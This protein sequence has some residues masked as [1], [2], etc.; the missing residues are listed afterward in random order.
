MQ[1]ILFLTI[2]FIQQT[3]AKTTPEACR[4]TRF[5]TQPITCIDSK[6]FNSYSQVQSNLNQFPSEL[7]EFSFI[8][9]N[10]QKLKKLRAAEL[11]KYKH[12]YRHL[13]FDYNENPVL[14]KKHQG[15]FEEIYSDFKILLETT[16]ELHIT[17][18][19]INI[20]SRQ[21]I[22]HIAFDLE[23]KKKELEKVKL[24]IFLK[25]RILAGNNIEKIMR[26][27]IEK[28]TTPS[29]ETFKSSFISDSSTYLVK[30][31]ETL[32]MYD[33]YLSRLDQN[34]KSNK[35]SVNQ[36]KF[37]DE[38]LDQNPQILEDIFASGVGEKSFSDPLFNKVSCQYYDKFQS[39]LQRQKTKDLIIDTSLVIGPFLLMGAGPIARGLS[40]TKLLK[41]GTPLASPYNQALAKSASFALNGSIIAYDISSLK[42]KDLE[43]EKK[44]TNLSL[45]S[46]EGAV[47]EINKCKEELSDMILLT[48]VG[49]GSV[50]MVKVSQHIS[51]VLKRMILDSHK[52]KKGEGFFEGMMKDLGGGKNQYI[53]EEIKIIRS[54]LRENLTRFDTLS[55]KLDSKKSAVQSYLK[56]N[57]SPVKIADFQTIPSKNLNLY[58][59]KVG[60]D[61]IELMYIPGSDIPHMHKS[62]NR[63]GHVALRIG[64]KVYHQTGGSGFKIESL[65]DFINKTKKNYKVYGQVLESSPK[66]RAIME[67]YFQVMH[68]KQLP[69]SFLQNN[70]SQSVCRAFDLAQIKK[71]NSAESLD[72][73][74]TVAKIK[75]S[76]RVVMKTVYNEDKDVGHN[77]MKL[78][79]ASNRSLFYG[80]PLATGGAAAYESLQ[81]VDLLI[82]F[83]EESKNAP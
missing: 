62:V 35:A 42:N 82:N 27:A 32:D 46:S 28:D 52:A 6:A 36:K 66:E 26:E 51:P 22:A 41:F 57:E 12:L 39:Y 40:L 16:R 37:I 48:S 78:L 73:I 19:K 68:E 55:D 2:L 17:Q 54:K 65:D 75:R 34:L 10:I 64:D 80:L 24:A 13:A 43:C 83:M 47:L 7:T 61:S 15:Q 67:E 20:L 81:M 25:N 76:D 3:I 72:P 14:L 30:Q 49:L 69:Y 4:D 77:Q 21:K 53:K 29:K 9:Q 11:D 79:T 33:N 63:V 18:E 50:G 56:E 8:N 5:S 45:D 1:R 38:S 71:Y 31:R 70:C 59:E 74:L 23:D 60:K 58:S 44:F